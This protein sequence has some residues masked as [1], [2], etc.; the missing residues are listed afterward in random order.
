ME[1]LNEALDMT[2]QKKDSTIIIEINTLYSGTNYNGRYKW[3]RCKIESTHPVYSEINILYNSLR[4]SRNKAAALLSLICYQ[5]SGLYNNMNAVQAL[6]AI[7]RATGVDFSTWISN[8]TNNTTDETS[9][10]QNDI[11]DTPKEVPA[12]K[13]AKE[14]CIEAMQK[15]INFFSEFQFT[16]SFRFVNTLTHTIL[17][18]TD[19][20]KN[21][22]HNYFALL[23]S[24]YVKEISE[25]VKSAEF[26]TIIDTIKTNATPSTTINK[27]IK[28]YYGSAGT[29]KTT[30]A[31]TE[32]DNRCIVCN[33]SMLPADLMEDF[34]FE[35]GHPSFNPSLLWDCMEKGLPVVLDEINL[36]PFDS[37]RFL[38][39]IVDGKTEFYYKNRAVHIANGFQIIGTMNL[40]LNGMVY[41][42]PEPLVDRCSQIQEF[43]LTAEQLYNA[44]A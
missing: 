41:G 38:Q 5:K 42:L 10:E 17:T 25:K 9:D 23:D 3:V 16:P 15:L 28:I 14:L 7:E 29:G 24:P 22:I 40:T 2:K 37:L 1:I 19:K 34:C 18:Q 30:L 44:V 6:N 11:E 8:T 31:Q 13:T 36:L 39:G 35:N 21:Y 43:K 26:D 27:R 33:N 32:T 20:V 4:N 12:Q